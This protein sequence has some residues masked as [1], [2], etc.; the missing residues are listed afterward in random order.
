MSYFYFKNNNF[1]NCQGMGYSY[2]KIFRTPYA[3]TRS[4]QV[5]NKTK[6]NDLGVT[7]KYLELIYESDGES[8]WP[9]GTRVLDVSL[10]N[11]GKSR[12]DL[13]AFAANVA[14]EKAFERSNFA[15]DYDYNARQQV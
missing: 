8:N 10:K 5:E 13:W 15:C 7:A 9:P 4:F 3:E 14:L 2:K 12:A 6:D 1:F 11:S